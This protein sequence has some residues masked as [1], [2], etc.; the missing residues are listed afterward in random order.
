EE[1]KTKLEPA[2]ALAAHTP[3]SAGKPELPGG[4]SG[5]AGRPA[6]LPQQAAAKPLTGGGNPDEKIIVQ[7]HPGAARGDDRPWA[8]D[9]AP[10]LADAVGAPAEAKHVVSTSYAAH[11]SDESGASARGSAMVLD[12]TPG[13]SIVSQTIVEAAPAAEHA[14][15]IGAAQP[16]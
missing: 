10:L 8:M 3:I 14:G 1:P 4:Q 16:E 5:P 9:D 6:P 2:A 15:K 12:G 11:A 13:A 7:G